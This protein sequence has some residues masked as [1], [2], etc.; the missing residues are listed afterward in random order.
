MFQKALMV[1]SNGR[2]LYD[3]TARIAETVA[4]AAL[5]TGL[6]HV[7]L[8][9]T[10]ASLI[11]NENADPD[12]LADLETFLGSLVPDGDQR[13]RHQAEGPDDMP[14]HVRLMLTHSDLTIPVRDGRLALGTWQG[15]FL[16]EHRHRPHC[17][18]LIVTVR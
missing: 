2:G 13:Y 3:I 5:D 12:V 18:R 11:I 15:V 1:E 4:S 8:Q 10:S 14:A 6:C 17:R 9:H 16:Y 7:F